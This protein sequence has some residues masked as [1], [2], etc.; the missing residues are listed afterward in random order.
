MIE[1]HEHKLNEALEKVTASESLADVNS[2]INMRIIS[3]IH[4]KT[5]F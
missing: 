1:Y 4:D 3:R 5:E 2:K